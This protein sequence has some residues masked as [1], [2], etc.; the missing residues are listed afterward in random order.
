MSVFMKYTLTGTICG[1]TLKEFAKM[2]QSSF[3]PGGFQMEIPINGNNI[4]VPFDWPSYSANGNDDGTMTVMHGCK[5]LF[6]T[7]DDSELD[8]CFEDDWARLGITREDLTAETL[9]KVSKIVEF[10]IDYYP[11]SED[12]GINPEDV[13]EDEL[14]LKELCF[15]DGNDNEYPVPKSIL[16]ATG[17][18][19]EL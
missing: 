5:T 13:K 16:D 4:C 2:P 17:N 6:S 12:I 15:I 14:Y 8:D 18:L 3:S 19:L 9:A 10:Y 1:K 11:Y 7:G